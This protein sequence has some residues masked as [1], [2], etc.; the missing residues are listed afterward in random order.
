MSIPKDGMSRIPL[1]KYA[2]GFVNYLLLLY[3]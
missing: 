3:Y 1:I 2:Y